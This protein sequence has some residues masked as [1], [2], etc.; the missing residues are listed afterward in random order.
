MTA[1]LWHRSDLRVHDSP[2][3]AATEDH[4]EVYPVFVVDPAFYDEGANCD[5]RVE[6]VLRCVEELDERY[7]EIGSSVSVLHGESVP[8]LSAVADEHDATVYYGRDVNAGYARER[9]RRAETAGFVGVGE[10]GIVREDDPREDWSERTERWFESPVREPPESLPENR[11]EDDTTVEGALEEYGV[12]PKK[13]VPEPG[14]EAALDRLEGFLGRMDG[15]VRSIS[16]PYDAEGNRDGEGTSYL[17]PYFSVGALSLRLAYQRANS[18]QGNK[19]AIEAF[20]ER[21]FWNRHYTQ[22]LH[23]FPGLTERAV[24]PVY[25]GMNRNSH[26][27]E[28]VRAW[29]EGKTGYPLVDAGMRA[30]TD[31]GWL[32]FRTRAMVASFFTYILK[33]PWWIGARH[34]RREL[35]D[36]DTAINYAQWQAQSGLVGVHPNRVYN[37]TKQANENDPDGNYIRKYVPELRP[38]PDEYIAEPWKAPE[39]VQQEAG[40]MVGEGGEYP[41]PVVEYKKEARRAREAFAAVSD[42]AREALSDPEVYTRASLPERHPREELTTTSYPEPEESDQTELDD[43]G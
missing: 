3:L 12:E 43:F 42:R 14:E 28:L 26:D 39:S 5:A 13:P 11:I 24:N 22:K 29:K 36:G 9:D 8:R 4:D 21:L 23:D 32:N 33:Q 40:V 6:F 27:P 18:K 34:M 37:P 20:I 16:P 17:S 7:S 15:Y 30:L 10:D 41:E 1:I 31:R 35:I 25:R 2:A 19:K 38:V